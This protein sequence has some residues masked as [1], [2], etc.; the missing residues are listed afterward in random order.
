[1]MISWIV[2]VQLLASGQAID[3]N[4]ARTAFAEGR[5]AAGR[6]D[7]AL[8]GHSLELPILFVH[9][10]T[11]EVVA[12]QPDRG[13]RLAGADGLWTGT[14]PSDQPIANFS[15]EWSGTRW[16]ML[17]WPPPA[18]P[19]ARVRLLM[20]E[21][22]HN[23]QQDLRISLE[24]SPCAH[25]ETYAGRLWLRLEARALAAALRAGADELERDDA[26]F[27]AMLLRAMRRSLFPGSPDA[28]DALERVEG[29]AEY[30][31]VYLCVPNE[32]GRADL[33]VTSLEELE[34][35]PTLTRS[36]QYATGPALGLLLDG[37]DPHWR[38]DFVSGRAL[39]DI[40]TRALAFEAPEDR[41]D[42]ESEA[43]QCAQ[44]YDFEAVAAEEAG[45]ERARRARVAEYRR[46]FVDGPVLILPARAPQRS[47]DPNQI[48]HIDGL[49]SAYGTLWISDAWGVADAPGGALLLEDLRIHLAA[50]AHLEGSALAGEGWTV[51][52]APGWRVIPGAREG[53]F[54]VTE[55]KG[56]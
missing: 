22:F 14:Y 16:T 23:L 53:D 50:P 32:R 37:Y 17:I 5:A 45:I 21:S 27:D 46:R 40:L 41:E 52:L 15:T 55:D 4:V 54:T 28:E 36:F 35:R 18:E 20:H 48:E 43:L 10:E 11:R 1:M 44:K 6:D 2:G 51:E 49:G 19:V 39:A 13:G 8:W 29:S 34:G 47:F 26:V 42:L 33:V 25:L 3:R 31:G 7:G 30:T 12:N 24:S 38:E 9:P 56:R